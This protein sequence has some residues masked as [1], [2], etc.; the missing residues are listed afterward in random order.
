MRRLA[1]DDPL[2]ELPACSAGRRDA[3]RMALVEPEVPQP[4]RGAD[5]RRAVRRIGDGAVVDLLDA[6]LAEGGNAR[7]RR[8][9]VGA[10]A[11]E[12]L[13]KEFVFAVRRRP[14]DIAG[15]RAFFVWAEQEPARF[16]AHVP[17]GIR[18]AQNSHFRQ[19]LRLA[20][21]DRG[22]GFGHDILVLD[23]DDGD[24]DPDHPAGRP[25][26]IAGRRNDMLAHHLALV[27]YDLPF[28]V[29]QPLD[30]GHRRLA[31][32]L[33][34]AF[35]RA[36][37]QSLREIGGLDVAVVGMLDRADD[38]LDIAERPDLLDL[39]WLQEL[40]LD[41]DRLGDAGVIV[42]FV[43]PVAGAREADVRHLAKAD[44]EAGLLFQ[45]AVERDR[46][47]MDLSDRVAEVEQRQETRRMPGR[48]GSQLPALNEDA[49]GPALPGEMVERR[50]ADHAPANDQSPRVRSHSHPLDLRRLLTAVH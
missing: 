46:I 40:H 14:I 42:I 16:L 15:G 6:D 22:M 29:R 45:R 7:D 31:V 1:F 38:P 28:A 50:D 3:E 25:G 13:G 39:I 10:K 2:G 23:R 44:V 48:A 41:A 4:R 26:E 18:L 47:F 20:L 19:A 35:A 27:G 9:D 34:A 12:V 36:A 32:D 30:R 37:G 49:V 43:H 8:F 11:I 33:G 17:G 21:D 5:D 24:I